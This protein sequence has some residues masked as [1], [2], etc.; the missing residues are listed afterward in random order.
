[1]NGLVVSRVL[2]GAAV[3]SGIV[4]LCG[5]YFSEVDVDEATA[6]APLIVI[7]PVVVMALLLLVW[8]RRSG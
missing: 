5:V 1:M 8:Q 2:F 7:A 6:T 3:G 4:K